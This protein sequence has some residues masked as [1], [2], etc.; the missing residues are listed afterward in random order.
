M[1]EKI[2]NNFIIYLYTLA[3]KSNRGAL[4]DL[5]RGLS[6]Q[7][8]TN[9]AM[10]PYVAPWVPDDA[11][12]TW[13]EKVYYIVAALFANYQAG[14]AG[15]NLSTDKGNLGDHCRSLVEKKLVEKK[16]Q[17]ASFESRF[18]CVL[19]AHRDDVAIMLKQVLAMLRSEEI[20]INWH[21]IFYDLQYWNSESQY[22][23]RQW[24][25]GFWVYQK[26]DNN[27]EM[28]TEEK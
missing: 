15:K 25:N 11:R 6:G 16:A 12:N 8:G 23:Q 17:S 28:D 13:H 10:F 18:T 19:K 21:Q 4:A 5:R 22:V 7:P 20:P 1:R 24:A 27:N 14:S 26:P 3:E 2:N 9:P